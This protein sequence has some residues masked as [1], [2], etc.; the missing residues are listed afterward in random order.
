MRGS[1]GSREPGSM[2]VERA[3]VDVPSGL[4]PAI[5]S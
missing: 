1:I 4:W 3:A 2:L 5:F